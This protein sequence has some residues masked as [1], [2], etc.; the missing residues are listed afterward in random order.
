M[1]HSKELL[2]KDVLILFHKK[3]KKIRG[4]FF[5]HIIGKVPKNFNLLKE[6]RTLCQ[7]K[8]FDSDIHLTKGPPLCIIKKVSNGKT[9]V[10]AIYLEKLESERGSA[11]V[12][13]TISFL[14]QTKVI[15]PYLK[16]IDFLFKGFFP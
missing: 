5:K 2:K 13:H 8:G 4:Y 11:I 6:T 15:K 10:Q 12:K 16:E 9:T 3:N 1:A 7:V 14:N